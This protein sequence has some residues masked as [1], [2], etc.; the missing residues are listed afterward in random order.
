MYIYN[1]NFT[2]NHKISKQMM[3]N[4]DASYV[5]QSGWLKWQSFLK[6]KNIL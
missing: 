4:L 6:R 3:C 2:A 5:G 1:Y